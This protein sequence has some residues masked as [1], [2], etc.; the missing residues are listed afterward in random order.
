M[1]F[2]ID[3]LIVGSVLGAEALGL[4]T[5]A[6]R[7]PQVV[8]L[9]VFAVLSS[10]AFPMFSRAR[11]DPARLKRGYVTSVRLLSA[12]G[13][14][15][16]VGLF[17]VAPMLVPVVF[18]PQW[19]AAVVPLEALS[20]YAAARSL[21]AG[22]VDVYKGTGRPEIGVA[23]ALV[24]LALLVPALVLAAHHGG[25]DAVA[26]TQAALALASRSGCSRS[27]RGS[28]VLRRRPR[29]P[30]CAPLSRSAAASRGRRRRPLGPHRADGLQLGG[31]GRGRGRLRARALWRLTSGS[32]G[33]SRALLAPGRGRPGGDDVIRAALDRLAAA[34]IPFAPRGDQPIDD[35][36][37]AG[38]STY[39]WAT[40]TL[41]RPARVLEAPGLRRFGA[42]GHRGHRF[43]L[44]FDAEGARWLKLDLN[45]VP[46]PRWDLNAPGTPRASGASPPTASAPRP[47][48]VRER[49]RVALLRRLP[50]AATR[51][52]AVIALLGP[53]GAGKGTVITQLQSRDSPLR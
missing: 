53:D 49:V 20:L 32:S 27:R 25:I 15:A 17:M 43:Y 19:S 33:S 7:L 21:G 37:P 44:A 46:A 45:L 12:Y 4:Y 11:A 41:A 26:W 39:S 5:L 36:P 34:G 48:S 50:L 22:A 16:G 31:G 13:V 6:F 40:A 51:R 29:A 1:I 18:G 52:G 9:G 23:V 28:S 14:A 24:R 30:R 42:A 2:D 3:Y 10:V 38:T 35:P 47:G 8:I